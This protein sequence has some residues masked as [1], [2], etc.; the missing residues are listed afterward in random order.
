[1][2]FRLDYMIFGHNMG[3]NAGFITIVGEE[4]A[5]VWN[6]D[7]IVVR[8]GGYTASMGLAVGGDARFR[9]GKKN[10]NTF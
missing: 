2:I 3:I 8:N 6:S 5:G 4:S 1:M 9:Y 7:K 10:R